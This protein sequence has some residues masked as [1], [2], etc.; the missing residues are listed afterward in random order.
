MNTETELTQEQIDRQDF[1]DNTIREFI[2]K[3]SEGKIDFYTPSN[4][5]I[6]EIRDAVEGM[7]V[8]DYRIMTSQEFYPY[9]DE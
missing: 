8:R 6:G 5:S 9:F 7:L 2:E 1:V 4:S 3:I